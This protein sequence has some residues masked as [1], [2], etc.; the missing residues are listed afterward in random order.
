MWMLFGVFPKQFF[1]T[2][3]MSSGSLGNTE[4]TR[5]WDS[6]SPQKGSFRLRT[7]L[8]HNSNSWSCCSYLP[9]SFDMA[10]VRIKEAAGRS[11]NLGIS[12]GV[13]SLKIPV[14]EWL[15]SPPFPQAPLH[16]RWFNFP[17]VHTGLPWTVYLSTKV[18]QIGVWYTS[19]S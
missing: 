1:R 14:G 3:T 12:W 11:Y 2:S 17:Q 8:L 5:T 10:Y 19:P 13:C 9:P 18:S 7:D 4:Q 6:H 16:T 15:I